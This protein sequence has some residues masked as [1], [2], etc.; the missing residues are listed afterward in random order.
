M[1]VALKTSYQYVI[2]L[3]GPIASGKGLAVKAI[4][5]ELGDRSIQSILLSDY[6][7]EVVR[8]EGLPLNRDTLREAG[9]AKRKEQGPGAW[10]EEMLSRLPTL[11]GTVLI[12]DSIRNPGEI[13]ALHR[14]FGERLFV[15]ATDAPVEDRIE[16]VLMRARLDDSTDPVEVERAMRIEME[17]NPEYGFAIERC[18]EMA[19]AVSLGKELKQERV[20][21][22]QERV[23]AFVEGLE[24]TEARRE[25][26]R[27]RAA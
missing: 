27:G 24:E 13:E 17:D 16:R 20:A 9:N 23:R 18:R 10:V 3:T 22:I 12:V 25:L 4:R 5:E 1:N 2:G 21:E 15:I 14:A 7:R 26:R 6:I 19:D 11:G 8:A